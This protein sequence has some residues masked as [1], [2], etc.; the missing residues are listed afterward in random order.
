MPGLGL[1][2]LSGLAPQIAALILA[3]L[4][5]FYSIRRLRRRGEGEVEGMQ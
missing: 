1:D 3:V 2:E 4:S 5:L